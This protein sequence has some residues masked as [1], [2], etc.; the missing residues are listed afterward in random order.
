MTGA[1][2]G[3][4]AARCRGWLASGALLHP[5]GGKASLVDLARAIARWAGVDIA[6]DSAQ[7]HETAAGAV[8]E[9]EHLVFILADGLGMNLLEALPATSFLRAHFVHELRTVYPSSTAPALTTLATGEWPATHAI[10]GWWTR[11]PAAGRTA[12]ILPFVDRVSRRPL[13]ELGVQVEAAFPSP[14]LTSAFAC[15][16]LSVLPRNIAD[17]VVSGYF[18]GGRARLAYAKL[19]EAVQAI[20]AR[21]AGAKAQTYTYWYIPT[22]DATEHDVGP[23]HERSVTAAVDV[24]Q[25]VARLSGLLRGRARI[26]LTADHG[27]TPAPDSP[28]MLESD[29]PLLDMLVG[30]PTGE[31]RAPVFHAR[32]GMAGAFA[33]DFRGRFGERY[34]L[35][36]VDEAEDLQLYG[37]VSHFAEEA[38]SR[39]GDCVAVPRSRDVLLFDP[40]GEL[41]TMRGFH[42]G[43]QPD[44]M[45][46]PLVVA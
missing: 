2:F 28:D 40:T 33:R 44:E 12:T 45:R 42:G 7:G 16:V 46:I 34:A 35:L 9:P 43:L 10:T 23:H 37:L 13:Q 39:L 5:L 22:I 32:E 1:P 11:L 25:H 26:V 14:A 15:D 38:R 41:R 21:V 8:G 18:A 4:D 36:T 19:R 24:D 30:P 20:A 17:S 27:V 29:D 3:E 6:P 31:P